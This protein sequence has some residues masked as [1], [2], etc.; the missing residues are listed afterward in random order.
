MNAQQHFEATNGQ[1]LHCFGLSIEGAGFESV[2]FFH[3]A[4]DVSPLRPHFNPATTTTWAECIWGGNS[5]PWI[6]RPDG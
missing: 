2:Q 3:T 5:R 4:G 1:Y 6:N